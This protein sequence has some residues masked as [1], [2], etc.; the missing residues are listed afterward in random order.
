MF[1]TN[2]WAND[3]AGE[4]ISG[5]FSANDAACELISGVFSANDAA[6]ELAGG[7]ILD[8]QILWP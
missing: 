3:A 7:A 2:N 8:G 6:G 1:W 5:V 4:L